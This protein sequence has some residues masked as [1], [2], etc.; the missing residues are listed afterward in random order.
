MSELS[1]GP[2]LIEDLEL[3]LRLVDLAAE[4]ACPLFDAGI[5]VET[6]ADGTPVTEADLNVERELIH[7]LGD[8][9]PGDAVLSEESGS[10]GDS[11]RRWIIDP[12][13][14]TEM[15]VTGRETWGTHLALAIDGDVVLGVV[16]RPASKRRWWAARGLGA[17]TSGVTGSTSD[18]S[19]RVS[20]VASLAEGRVSV[21]SEGPS[22]VVDRLDGLTTLVEPGYDDYLDIVDGRL[23]AVLFPHPGVA[24]AWDH[25]PAVIM[26]A[27]AGGRF[28]DPSGGTRIDVGTGVFSNGRIDGE[29]DSAI[30]DHRW[31]AEF[32][33]HQ[34]AV[35]TGGPTG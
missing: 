15:F 7:V 6:K 18:R 3:A 31:G 12:I 1:G 20:E 8:E 26:I 14:G 23:D 33:G 30:A 17:H 29:L 34:P 9:R 11:R 28:R 24:F 4:I 16:S 35:T 27:E 21:W 22:R 13:D 19:L 2:H 5:A 10:S 32:L 25:A